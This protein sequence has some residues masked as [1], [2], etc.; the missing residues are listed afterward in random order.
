MPGPLKALSL[1]PRHHLYIVPA[2]S[3]QLRFLAL[4]DEVEIVLFE[5]GGR[6]TCPPREIDEMQRLGEDR[7]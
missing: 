1:P 7:D 6:T 5:S 3:A 2:R 4:V